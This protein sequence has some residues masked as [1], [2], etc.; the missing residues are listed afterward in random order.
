MKFNLYLASDT[1]I[2][3]K[4]PIWLNVIA[5]NYKNSRKKKE[6]NLHD[7]R[8]GIFLKF[9]IKRKNGLIRHQNTLW[10]QEYHKKWKDNPEN[11]RK[12]L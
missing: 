3:S 6:A 4:W 8:L 1:K 11:G 7:L 9:D 5:N 2:N 10:F 12:Y